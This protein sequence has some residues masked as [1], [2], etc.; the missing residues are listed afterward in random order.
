MAVR[1]IVLASQSPYRRELLARLGVNF[2]CASPDLDEDA[3]KE[4]ISSSSLLAKT[5]ARLKAQKVLAKFPNHLVIGAD[6]VL[7]L[8]GEIFSKPGTSQRAVEQL[9]ELSGKTHKLITAVCLAS[10]GELIEF[11]NVAKLTMYP[12]NAEEI[13]NYVDTD[14]PLNCAGSYKIE[15]AGIRLFKKIEADDFT[16]IVGLPLI[17]LNAH[18]RRLGLANGLADLNLKV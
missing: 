13:Q 2:E 17:Q 4:K 11:E 1:P 15:S 16:S 3:T 14:K 7:D 8:E 9:E 12:L 5:L 18:L 10:S 6:Q